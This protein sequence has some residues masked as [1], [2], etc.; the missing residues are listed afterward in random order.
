MSRFELGQ[1][2]VQCD[3]CG[4]FVSLDDLESGAATRKLIHADTE[5]S[6]ESYETEC[7]RCK[8]KAAP[9]SAEEREEG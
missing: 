5:F 8:K 2:D 6:C 3:G 4:R 9:T 1:W 7:A